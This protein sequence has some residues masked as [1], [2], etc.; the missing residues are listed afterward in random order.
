[1]ATSLSFTADESAFVTQ[2]QN[3]SSS[4]ISLDAAGAEYEASPLLVTG[5]DNDATQLD[6]PVAEDGASLPIP[7]ESS[8]VLWDLTAS[9]PIQRRVLTSDAADTEVVV[10]TSDEVVVV[11]PPPETECVAPVKETKKRVRKSKV[12]AVTESTTDT[13]EG[14][15][16]AD[17][18][19]GETKKKRSRGPA[20]KTA[21][22]VAVTSKVAGEEAAEPAKKAA[23]TKKQGVAVAPEA[24]GSGG[25]PKATSTKRTR[26]VSAV[27]PKP[28]EVLQRLE[29]KAGLVAAW[30]A[31]L[32]VSCTGDASLGVTPAL[33][34]LMELSR[35][36]ADPTIERLIT[37]A[38]GDVVTTAADNAS[39]FSAVTKAAVDGIVA[40]TVQGSL[41]PLS[42]LTTKVVEVLSHLLD[43]V[44][45][46]FT[47]PLEEQEMER[48]LVLK[49][50]LL[51]LCSDNS[52][53]ALQEHIKVV[54]QRK[55]YGVDR[56]C[57]VFEAVDQSA[58]RVW[59]LNDAHVASVFDKWVAVLD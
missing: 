46:L 28:V 33:H 4:D 11:T 47:E 25:S 13:S 53:V 55:C 5:C 26:E 37:E 43:A 17:G 1:V 49:G 50:V 42:V 54:A 40:R 34:Q 9:S 44:H 38:A 58:A 20:K 21:V 39:D 22:A 14:A 15:D 3:E 59:E 51:S 24:E 16:N 41:E 32:A 31:D 8:T 2:I 18:A 45:R 10:E 23:R 56:K 12:V 57:N 19:E 30:A 35:A 48:L 36:D 27:V 6:A 52:A 7:P 29:V